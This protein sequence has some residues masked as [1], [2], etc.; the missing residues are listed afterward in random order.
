MIFQEFQIDKCQRGEVE[1]GYRKVPQDRKDNNCLLI[2]QRRRH[3]VECVFLKPKTLQLPSESL[4]FSPQFFFP[5]HHNNEL[6]V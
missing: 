3:Q 6:S 4:I 1:K 2:S 5:F